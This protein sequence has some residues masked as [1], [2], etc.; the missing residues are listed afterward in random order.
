MLALLVY[1][2]TK[3]IWLPVFDATLLEAHHP[4]EGCRGVLEIDVLYHSGITIHQI[5]KIESVDV[6]ITPAADIF[7]VVIF[8]QD[9][10][11]GTGILGGLVVEAN[12]RRDVIGEDPYVNVVIRLR[13]MLQAFKNEVL[14][15]GVSSLF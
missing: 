2:G 1:K 4:V 8:S 5:P 11:A 9:F 14:T 13:G 10:Q 7:C 15:I 6:N 12:V 3:A